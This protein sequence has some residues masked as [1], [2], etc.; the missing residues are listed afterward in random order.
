M[1]A[2]NLPANTLPP[3]PAR[4]DPNLAFSDD[5]AAR[6]APGGALSGDPTL[7]L[8]TYSPRRFVMRRTLAR[9]FA[10]SSPAD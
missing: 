8:S 3:K 9:R 5:D 7:G 6:I 10:R 4:N 2:S 1:V